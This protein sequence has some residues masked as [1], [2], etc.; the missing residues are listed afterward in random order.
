MTTIITSKRCKSQLSWVLTVPS[1][2]SII[3][4]QDNNSNQATSNTLQSINSQLYLKGNLKG[5]KTLTS[6]NF[7]FLNDKTNDINI[8]IQFI[9]RGDEIELGEFLLIIQDE[10]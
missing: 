4:Y 7:I 5:I 3:N 2:E 6:S 9:S 8:Y 10:I 1:R